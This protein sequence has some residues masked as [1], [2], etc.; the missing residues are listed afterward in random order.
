MAFKEWESYVFDAIDAIRQ[1]FESDMW[2]FST[3]EIQERVQE[4]KGVD[5]SYKAIYNLVRKIKIERRGREIPVFDLKKSA[6][7]TKYIGY[8]ADWDK[9]Y[10]VCKSPHAQSYLTM[11]LFEP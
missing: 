9:F 10:S 1:D 6:G 2:S 5:M 4:D 7:K 11:R 3:R 8:V